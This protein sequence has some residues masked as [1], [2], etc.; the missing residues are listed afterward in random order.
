MYFYRERFHVAKFK[1]VLLAFYMIRKRKVFCRLRSNTEGLQMKLNEVQGK[2]K[3]LDYL[4]NTDFE[5]CRM[6]FSLKFF[7]ITIIK[8]Y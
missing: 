8:H 7:V 1:A 4:W 6:V 3:K 5:L 2:S